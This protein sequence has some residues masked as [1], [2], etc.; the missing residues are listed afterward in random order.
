[1]AS[2]V[3]GL[4]CRCRAQDR[5]R[6]PALLMSQGT[7]SRTDALLTLQLALVHLIGPLS[8]FAICTA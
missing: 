8:I 7:D 6:V 2:K 3:T 1:M 4:G 5:L